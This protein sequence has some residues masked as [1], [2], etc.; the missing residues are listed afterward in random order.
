[1]A[2][3]AGIAL[4]DTSGK[5]YLVPWEGMLDQRKCFMCHH[6]SKM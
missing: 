1:M 5:T 4:H 3:L 6:L 2:E